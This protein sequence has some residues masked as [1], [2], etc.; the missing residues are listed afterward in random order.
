MTITDTTS[1]EFRQK[2]DKPYF[3]LTEKYIG[4]LS[5]FVKKFVVKERNSKYMVSLNPH[6]QAM[7]KS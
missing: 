1:D 6:P 4:A 3:E 5:R 7:R 2:P